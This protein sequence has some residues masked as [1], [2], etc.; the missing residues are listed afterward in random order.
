MTPAREVFS[1]FVGRVVDTFDPFTEASRIAVAAQ[2]LVGLGNAVGRGPHFMVGE[3]RH[4][5]NEFV[6]IVGTSSHS[7]KG[8][9]KAIALH[10]LSEADAPW[11]CLV[12]SG[13]SSGEGLIYSVRDPSS[14]ASKKKES[15]GDI[16]TTDEGVADKRLLVVESEFSSVLKVAQREGNILS[17]VLRD[18]WDAKEVLRTLTKSSPTKATRPHISLIAHTTP[19]DLDR[20]LATVEAANG[21][22]NRLMFILAERSKLLPFPGRA[23]QLEVRKLVQEAEQIIE[24]GR[25]VGEIR[26][27]DEAREVWR[28]LYSDISKARMGMIG[29]LLARAEAHIRRIASIY[30]VAHLSNQVRLLDLESALGFW[31]YS[32][33][34]A[35]VIFSNR[36]GDNAADKIA[37]EMGEGESMGKQDIRAELFYGKISSARLTRALSLLVDLGI[38][39]LDKVQ[40]GEGRPTVLVTRLPDPGRISRMEVTAWAT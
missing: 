23:D 28:S 4:H 25:Q 19:E 11:G 13:L 2:L 38:V 18:A 10:V 5:L 15:F 16:E 29:S 32:E 22:G 26:F 35:R 30:A 24:F 1:G 6:A 8:D 31:D 39:S 27:D 37:S 20:Y 21:F 36:T 17:N 40:T 7:R 14:R 34:S 33:E 3:T 9:S 12:A